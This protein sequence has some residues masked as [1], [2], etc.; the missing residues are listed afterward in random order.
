MQAGAAHDAVHQEGG[1]RHVAEILQQEDEQEQDQD[2]RQEDQHAADARDDA[3]LDEALQQAR[4]Q[5]RVHGGAERV[6][7]GRN[8]VHQR[9]RPDEHRLEHHEQ[10]GEQDDEPGH[11]VEQD[12]SSRV[13][14]VSGLGGHAD[15][16]LQDAVGFALGGAQIGGRVGG[17]QSLDRLACRSSASAASLVQPA[18]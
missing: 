16:K 11:R 4:R 2:L 18:R 7:A 10:D 1:A 3:V 17:V 12:A 13:V 8:E 15:G 14:S 9:L 6:E 5:R